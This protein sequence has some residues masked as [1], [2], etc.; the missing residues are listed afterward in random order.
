[1]NRMTEEGRKQLEELIAQVMK[2][3]QARGIAVGIVDSKNKTRY[4]Q[5]KRNDQIRYKFKIEKEEKYDVFIEVEDKKKVK[6]VGMID[7]DD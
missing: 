6:I 4:I 3:G 2:D 5:D 7:I 1:M